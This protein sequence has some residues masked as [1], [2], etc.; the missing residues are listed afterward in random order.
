MEANEKLSY[1]NGAKGKVLAISLQNEKKKNL[2]KQGTSN[3]YIGR[4]FKK[5]YYLI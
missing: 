1:L 3:M 4:C 2:K 5:F